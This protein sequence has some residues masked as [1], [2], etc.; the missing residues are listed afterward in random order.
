M[1]SAYG[2]TWIVRARRLRETRQH[3]AASRRAAALYFL[4]VLAGLAAASTW[5]SGCIL[6]FVGVFAYVAVI[7]IT[8]PLVD[9]AFFRYSRASVANAP[10]RA[11]LHWV[12]AVLAGVLASIVIGG[13]AGC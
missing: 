10:A 3:L 7:P 4:T 2:K 5:V 8:W 13:L 6:A 9:A 12:A 11:R 1:A